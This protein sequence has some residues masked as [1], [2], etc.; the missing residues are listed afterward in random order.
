[1]IKEGKHLL[2]EDKPDSHRMK[3]IPIGSFQWIVH[4]E[5]FDSCLIDIGLRIKQNMIPFFS[6]NLSFDKQIV[7]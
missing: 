1:V 2:K 3:M 4:H 5:P 6:A 7:R